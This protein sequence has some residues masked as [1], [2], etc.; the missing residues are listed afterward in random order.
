MAEVLSQDEIDALLQSMASGEEDPVFDEQEEEESGVRAYDFRRPDKLSKEQLR[1]LQIIH[2]NYGRLLTTS[3]STQL[4]SMVSFDVASIEQLS[5]DEFIR[6]L[7]QPTLIGIS[8]LPAL[9]GQFIIELNPS[10]GYLIIDRLF[11]GPGAG[12]VEMRNMTDIEEVIFR[13]VFH[14]FLQNIPEAW[15]NVH[16]FDP[17]LEDI[18]TNP[19]FTQIVPGNDT[20][21]LVTFETRI[22]ESSGLLNIC[23]PFI[24]LEP[25]V[26][27][28]SA[29]YWFS[30]TRHAQ[31][32]ENISA[33]RNKI[34][35]ARFPVSVE[36][37]SAVLTLGDLLNLQEGDIIELDQKVDSQM[38]VRV[39]DHVKFY[40]NP[41]LHRGRKALKIERSIGEEGEEDE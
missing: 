29:Q 3:L 14:W 8:N 39:G 28:L 1:T 6:S 33:L 30:S 12:R 38:K 19:Y 37:G 16:A 21:I 20:V 4:R 5:Y 23:Y 22:M 7:P 35:K 15:E 9:D 11:G 10:V 41:G 26:S 18:E 17:Y 32:K 25:I 2:D 24:L 31:S 40:G 13:K 27:R 34:M 36:L